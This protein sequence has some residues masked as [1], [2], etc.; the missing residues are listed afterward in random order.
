MFVFDDL[1]IIAAPIQGKSG[2]FGSK[3]KGEKVNLRVLSEVDGG[4]GKVLDVKDWCG[5]QGRSSQFGTPMMIDTD[6]Y[7]LGHNSLFAV[8]TVSLYFTAQSPSIN[9]VTT[10]YTLPPPSS[11]SPRRGSMTNTLNCPLLTTVP[12]YLSTLA[13]ATTA[14]AGILFSSDY[15]VDDASQSGLESIGEYNEW[16]AGAMGCAQ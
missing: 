5:W 15:R 10:A 1:V 14:A 11:S 12:Q 4:I 7:V 3:K 6:V 2:L 13:Q 16:Q 8:T 9:P